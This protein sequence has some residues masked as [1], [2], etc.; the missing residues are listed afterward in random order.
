MSFNLCHLKQ[1]LTIRPEK[2]T[3]EE[4]KNLVA[5]DLEDFTEGRRLDG[6]RS[7]VSATHAEAQLSSDGRGLKQPEAREHSGERRF[8][9]KRGCD[10]DA[11]GRSEA[12]TPTLRAERRALP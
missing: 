10:N 1:S 9:A 7:A 2:I 12:W 5:R 6:F 8:W 4:T 3:A 11:S